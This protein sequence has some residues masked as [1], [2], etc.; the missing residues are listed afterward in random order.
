[1]VPKLYLVI[2]YYYTLTHICSRKFPHLQ[3]HKGNRGISKIF[4]DPGF[5]LPSPPPSISH[6]PA[7]ALLIPFLLLSRGASP[8][9]KDWPPACVLVSSPSSPSATVPNLHRSPTSPLYLL[10]YFGLFLG[11]N[12]S[13]S[14]KLS[15]RPASQSCLLPKAFVS[16][17]RCVA[18]YSCLSLLS[19]HTGSPGDLFLLRSWVT[20]GFQ[21][22]WPV[23]TQTHNKIWP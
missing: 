9:S 19:P 14:Q 6:W 18:V 2:P 4:P 16:V 3:F 1:M 12:E 7:P 10:V 5:P 20:S 11:P 23:Y 13:P 15:L 21:S 17:F 22:L 8:P